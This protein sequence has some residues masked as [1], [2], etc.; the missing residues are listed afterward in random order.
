MQTSICV[1]FSR[2]SE[3]SPALLARF[4]RGLQRLKDSGR[5]D[6]YR[7]EARQGNRTNAKP[8]EGQ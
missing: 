8:N 7:A 3:K 5:Y 1:A 4:N 2:Q 6:E